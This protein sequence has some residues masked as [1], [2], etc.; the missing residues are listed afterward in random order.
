MSMLS[1]AFL[2]ER[3]CRVLAG[4][5]LDSYERFLLQ[6]REYRA[7]LVDYIH[8]KDGYSSRKWFTDDPP[9]QEPF[10]LDPGTFDRSNMDM[11]RGW[12]LLSEAEADESRILAL[13]DMPEFRFVPRTVPEAVNRA[14]MDL[15][16]LIGM[17]MVLFLLYFHVFMKYD[18]R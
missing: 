9:G 18:A 12:R 16:I 17:N 3:I 4:T 13:D 15:A 11:E 7:Q 1:P 8:A 6:A 10:V 14:A 2:Y 5:D